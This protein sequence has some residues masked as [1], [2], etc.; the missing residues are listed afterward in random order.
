L[1]SSNWLWRNDNLA[2]GG[3]EFGEIVP[4]EDH[5]QACATRCYSDEIKFA[6]IY[7]VTVT[8]LSGTIDAMAVNRNE[9]CCVKHRFGSQWIGLL[10]KVDQQL[11]KMV[12]MAF[13]MNRRG[14]Q[15]LALA[16]TGS[17]ITSL[18]V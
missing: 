12:S 3:L 10:P 4:T 5:R 13:F 17:V 8:I 1:F 14:R 11:P 2:K 15:Y 18:L 16:R 7:L 6:P 9:C